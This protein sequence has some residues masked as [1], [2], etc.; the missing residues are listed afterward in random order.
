MCAGLMVRT[1]TTTPQIPTSPAN[2]PIATA[3]RVLGPESLDS[4]RGDNP[5]RNQRAALPVLR[6]NGDLDQPAPAA[7]RSPSSRANLPRH[8]RLPHLPN[9]DT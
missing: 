9:P 2:H 4:D 5:A 3:A 1:T 8:S 7:A 6:A